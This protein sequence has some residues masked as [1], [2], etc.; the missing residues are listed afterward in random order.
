MCVWSV[1]WQPQEAAQTESATEPCATKG[2]TQLID[3]GTVCS[4]ASGCCSPP[5]YV[6]YWSSA[7]S[8]LFV[9]VLLALVV[10]SLL[11]PGCLSLSLFPAHCFLC[12]RD[13]TDRQTDTP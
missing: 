3:V 9:G 5:P 1:Q 6:H 10:S 2:T 12:R 11:A 13:E 7:L 4:I 8:W